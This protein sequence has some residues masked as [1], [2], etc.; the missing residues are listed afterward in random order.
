MI[1]EEQKIIL[2]NKGSCCERAPQYRR[3]QIRILWLVNIT[4][5]I[6]SILSI[7]CSGT[8][9]DNGYN[10]RLQIEKNPEVLLQSHWNI[11][12]YVYFVNTY[13][14]RDQVNSIRKIMLFV[15]IPFDNI[16]WTDLVQD[17]M[18]N[19]SITESTLNMKMFDEDDLHCR[20]K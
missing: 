7:P 3:P 4:I 5:V 15:D 8:L 19:F 11:R 13:K 16:R 18:L 9:C 17:F 1:Y 2:G 12:S 20:G 6:L 10:L 14:K